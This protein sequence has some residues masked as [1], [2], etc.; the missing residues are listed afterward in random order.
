MKIPAN[1]KSAIEDMVADIEGMY[2]CCDQPEDGSPSWDEYMKARIKVIR[3]FLN[4]KNNIM[5]K[6]SAFTEN[7]PEMREWLEG[8]GYERHTYYRDYDK[9]IYTRYMNDVNWFIS[10]NDITAA[11]YSNTLPETNPK[12]DID[13]RS[14]PTLF[15][16]IAAIR[17]DNDYMQWFVS[18]N[19]RDGNNNSLPDKW[20]LCTCNT[21]AEFG[22][23]N[24]SPNSYTKSEFGWH[25]ATIAE[26]IEHFKIDTED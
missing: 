5:F 21:L 11:R 10:T 14:N 23:M 24:N 9:Y 16:S 25:K 6:Y 15:Q 22:M 4:K 1:V 17:D 7:T 19:W 12:G 13:C 8:L 26:L 2:G 18:K 20:V 3:D